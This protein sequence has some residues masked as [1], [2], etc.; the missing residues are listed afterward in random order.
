MAYHW[1]VCFS[2]NWPQRKFVHIH[3]REWK[4]RPFAKLTWKLI[5]LP[6]IYGKI[7]LKFS[8]RTFVQ[9]NVQCRYFVAAVDSGP[10]S[11][12]RMRWLSQTDITGNQRI[13]IIIKR[14]KLKYMRQF[15]APIV[16]RCSCHLCLNACN[17]SL[18]AR[19]LSI[20]LPAYVISHHVRW[21]IRAPP[22]IT[23]KRPKANSNHTAAWHAELGRHL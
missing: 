3:Q 15:L 7:A 19:G 14:A 20:D 2:E 23:P 12:P 17:R 22:L 8:D 10:A 21:P 18:F 13:S 6:N 1:R 5:H 16:Y 11:L 4:I 9:N